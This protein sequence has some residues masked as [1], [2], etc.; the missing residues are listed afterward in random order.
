MASRLMMLKNKF[1]SKKYNNVEG[2]WYYYNPDNLEELIKMTY[3]GD[4]FCKY[5][6]LTKIH[7]ICDVNFVTKEFEQIKSYSD[8]YTKNLEFIGEITGIIGSNNFSSIIL[9]GWTFN[10]NKIS[11]KFEL[12]KYKLYD[13]EK[14]ISIE[15]KI[16]KSELIKEVVN[17]YHLIDFLRKHKKTIKSEQKIKL[18]R[19]IEYNNTK[20]LEVLKID[21]N[22]EKI[23]SQFSQKQ[24]YRNIHEEYSRLFITSNKKQRLERQSCK[25]IYDFF[26]LVINDE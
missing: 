14:N 26:P 1:V 25:S 21:K 13:L 18:E 2:N 17:I 20:K 4:N 9:L 11:L 12:D 8:I 22:C 23:N 10:G 3:D 6:Y 7:E 15:Y 16:G 24:P 5:S 19:E